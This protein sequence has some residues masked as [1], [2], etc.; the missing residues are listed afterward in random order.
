MD[1]IIRGAKLD[2]LNDPELETIKR[3]IREDVNRLLRKDYVNRVVITDVR[4]IE[5]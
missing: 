4:I 5:Q 3:L 2:E 1:T